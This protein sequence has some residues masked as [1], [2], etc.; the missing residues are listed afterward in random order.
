MYGS[1]SRSVRDDHCCHLCEVRQACLWDT[2]RECPWDR[3][4]YTPSIEAGV[5]LVHR[6]R[7]APRTEAGI[8][9]PL[10]QMTEAGMPLV[11]RQVSPWS[12]DAGMLLVQRQVY[13]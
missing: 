9:L 3:G 12:I 1:R 4:R 8:S 2:G 5:P 13:P 11:E 10:A 6:C 7:D